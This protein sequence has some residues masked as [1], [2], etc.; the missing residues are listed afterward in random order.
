MYAAHAGDSRAVM[1]V[2][3]E[4]R[5]ITEDHK[6]NRPDEKSRVESVGG[7]LEFSGCWRVVSKSTRGSHKAL[8]VSRSLGDREFKVMQIVIKLQRSWGNP[9]FEGCYQSCVCLQ[10]EQLHPHLS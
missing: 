2:G 3:E 5:R 9:S 7:S 10:N 1:C 4:V 8:A 6:P